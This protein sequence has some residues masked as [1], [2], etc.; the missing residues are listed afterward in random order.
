MRVRICYNCGEP[1]DSKDHL[2]PKAFFPTPAPS[3]LITM[4]CCT[5]CNNGFSL[6]DEKFRIFAA[7]D[8]QRNSAGLRILEQKVFSPNST[9]GRPFLEIAQTLRDVVVKQ[10]SRRILKP[11]LSMPKSEAQQFLFRLT[12]GLIA[13]FYPDLHGPDGNFYMEYL[14]DPNEQNPAIQ[15]AKKAVPFME[16]QDLGNGVFE[17]W[18]V[19]QNRHSVW[20]YSFYHGAT[21]MV[22]HS[23][24]DHPIFH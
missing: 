20:I 4:P 12:R 14:S 22:L 7:S 18:R 3:N 16:R 9:K 5:D 23:L 1:A 8:E 10:G 6:L 15:I 2:P 24:D 13:K 21:F 17:F 11:K 19:A